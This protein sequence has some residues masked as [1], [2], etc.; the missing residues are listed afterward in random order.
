MEAFWA[1]RTPTCFQLGFAQWF[2]TESSTQL[3]TLPGENRNSPMA[4][5]MP[6]WYLESSS[7]YV[8]VQVDCAARS[9]GATRPHEASPGLSRACDVLPFRHPPLRAEGYRIATS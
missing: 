7:R 1:L 2:S 5:P 4:K 9:R 3:Q 8:T 6:I